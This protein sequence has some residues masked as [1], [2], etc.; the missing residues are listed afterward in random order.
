MIIAFGKHPEKPLSQGVG[1]V[2][3]QRGLWDA[4]SFLYKSFLLFTYINLRKS[5]T[6]KYYKCN[7]QEN[8]KKGEI[9]LYEKKEK[10]KTHEDY[11]KNS[12]I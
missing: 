9:K 1:K 6:F 2:L 3:Y 4:L 10:K 5:L 7:I 11:H 8:M 12:F